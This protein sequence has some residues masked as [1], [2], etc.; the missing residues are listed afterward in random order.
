MPRPVDVTRG[1]LFP[2][3]I[4]LAAPVVLMQTADTAFHLVNMIWVGRLGAPATAALATAF[5]LMWTLYAL[6]NIAGTGIIANVARHVGAGEPDRAGYAAAQGLLLAVGLGLALAALSAVVLKP[7]FAWLGLAPDVRALAL[8]YLRIAFLAAPL[9][10]VFV[11]CEATMRAA[12][13]TRTPLLVIG[14]SLAL[15]AALDPLL[16]FGLG[17]FPRLG[18]PGA[19]LATVVAQAAAVA[20]FL[21]LAARRHP[22]FPLD[23]QALTRPAPR[24]LAALVGIGAPFASIGV[25]YSAVYLYFAWVTARFGTGPVAILGVG[26]RIESV[27]YLVA[28][29][30]GLA[31]ETLVGQNLG[32]RQPARAERAVWIATG[33]ISAFG[34]AFTVAMAVWPGAFLGLFL[35]DAGVIAAGV[36]YVRILAVGQLFTGLELVVNGGFSGAGDTRPPMLISLVVSLLR[37]PLAWWFAVEKGGGLLALGWV[38]SITCAVRGLSLVAWFSRGRWKTKALPTA[39][40]APVAAPDA[41][42]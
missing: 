20:W 35:S 19:A 33:L 29:E 26:N 3:V 25:L 15:N 13:D 5:F 37:V 41:A 18:V 4:R 8:S 36:G 39:R 7:L 32:A 22:A 27:V 34:A 28:A 1:P 6:T 21:A 2:A 31:C 40:L 24:Y 16:I 10:F 38:I 17:P 23:R 14:V 30:L 9:S 42:V 12:G 11:A